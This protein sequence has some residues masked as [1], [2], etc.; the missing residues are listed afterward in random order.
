M[1]YIPEEWQRATDQVHAEKGGRSPYLDRFLSYGNIADVLR[2]LDDLMDEFTPDSDELMGKIVD[3]KHAARYTLL[4]LV[5]K[6]REWS[7][8]P[9]E[10]E[11]KCRRNAA[12]SIRKMI[13]EIDLSLIH[14]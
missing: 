2:R 3:T 9:A 5:A 11:L 14:I 6:S 8:A 13:A 12:R 4:H 1:N 7:P 10:T